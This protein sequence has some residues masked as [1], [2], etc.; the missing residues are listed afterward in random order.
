MNK[1]FSK[2][3]SK[4]MYKCALIV[5]CCLIL[6]LLCRN[7]VERF[8][9]SKLFYPVTYVGDAIGDG[10]IEA[11]EAVGLTRPCDK[12]ANKAIARMKLKSTSLDLDQK[13]EL[14]S[15]EL[16][17]MGNTDFRSDE[18]KVILA[19]LLNNHLFIIPDV[20]SETQ[21]LQVR[22]LATTTLDAYKNMEN[23]YSNSEY[24]KLKKAFKQGEESIVTLCKVKHC[25]TTLKLE[26]NWATFGLGPQQNFTS[27]RVAKVVVAAG[28]IVLMGI[29]A[30]NAYVAAISQGGTKA[31]ALETATK[32]AASEAGTAKILDNI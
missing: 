12:K 22:W 14:I 31:A 9:F 32:A 27:K 21:E 11:S 17:T 5:L 13:V 6:L 23:I 26:K 2:G 4:R 10:L 7:K 15:R 1:G 18:G 24:N 25:G 28:T 29:V 30:E 20:S 3:F 8:S 19:S 16:G